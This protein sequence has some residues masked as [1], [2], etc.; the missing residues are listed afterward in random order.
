MS[1][2]KIII[3]KII[4]KSPIMGKGSNIP[5]II[6]TIGTINHFFFI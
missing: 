5:A 3:P 4:N 2:K 1:T 6:H